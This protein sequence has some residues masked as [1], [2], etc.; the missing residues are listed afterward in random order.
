MSFIRTLQLFLADELPVSSSPVVIS[1]E[2]ISAISN[3]G[4]RF[5]E[6][7]PEKV[8]EG[9]TGWELCLFS[10]DLSPGG[11]IKLPGAS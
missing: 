10:S 1:W 5:T 3:L 2:V 9:N 8:M 11:C 4:L 6:N 7:I